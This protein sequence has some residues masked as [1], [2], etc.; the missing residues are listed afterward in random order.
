LKLKAQFGFTQKYELNY[1]SPY[2]TKKWGFQFGSLYTTNKEI[3]Y[4]TQNNFLLFKKYEDEAIL[5]TRFRVGASLYKRFNAYS[6]QSFKVEYTNNTVNDRVTKELNQNYFPNG[7]N[8]IKYLRL[9]YS[10][11]YDKR[12]F[13]SYPEGGYAFS[14][15]A[16]KDGVG[17]GN[18]NA[19]SLYVDGEAYTKLSERWIIGGS[20][21]GGHTFIDGKIPFANNAAIGYN[22][23]V[24]RGYELYVMDGQSFAWYKTGVRFNVFDKKLKLGRY[25][26]I[27]AFNVLP[28]RLAL[29]A[30]FE[31]GYSY[32]PSYFETN[33][34]NNRHVYGGGPAL[35]LLILNTSLFSFE[36]N[37]NVR[38]E[39]GFFIKGGFKI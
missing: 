26:P 14:I 15:L 9:A 5:L 19:A 37:G 29:R 39:W 27:E 20:V 3:G 30:S 25:M 4:V 18:Y 22:I 2:F 36:Y 8:F 13:P 17:F 28:V 34:L 35:D 7:D 23:N 6:D 31:G 38:G 21:R 24:L 12:V 10:Y 16:I 1:T 11:T 33:T 32:E